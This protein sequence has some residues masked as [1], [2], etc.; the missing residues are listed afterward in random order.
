MKKTFAQLVNELTK[1]FSLSDPSNPSN[2]PD[3]STNG[4]TDGQTE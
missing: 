2:P 1:A 3:P 4:R